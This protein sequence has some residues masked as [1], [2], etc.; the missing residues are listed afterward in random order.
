MGRFTKKLN[1]GSKIIWILVI[2]LIGIYCF[3]FDGGL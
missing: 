3:V 1:K 2:I